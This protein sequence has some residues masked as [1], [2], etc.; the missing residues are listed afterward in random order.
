MAKAYSDDLRRKILGAHD[1]KVGSLRELAERFGTSLGY[2][3]KISAALRRTGRMERPPGQRRGRISRVTPGV[4]ER[5]R[6]LLRERPD[7]TL[8]ELQRQLQEAVGLSVSIT[9]LWVVLRELQLRLKKNSTPRNRTLGKTGSAGR[10][11]GRR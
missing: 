10:H 2:A 3:K 9:R 5:L 7:L 8:A 6:A 11:G 4:R 1:R